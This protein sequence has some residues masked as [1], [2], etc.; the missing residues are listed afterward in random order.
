MTEASVRKVLPK[1]FEWVDCSDRNFREAFEDIYYHDSDV[2]FISGQGGCGKSVLYELAYHLDPRH[3]KALASTGR[4]AENLRNASGIPAS[5]IHSGLGLGCSDLY[6]QPYM[7]EGTTKISRRQ[8]ECLEG[9]LTILIDEV[10]MVSANLMD[11]IFWLRE[12]MR[13]EHGVKIRL[14]LFGDPL[15]LPPVVTDDA[16]EYW[17]A[18]YPREWQRAYGNGIGFFSSE[19]FCTTPKNTVVLKRV[20]RQG[21][22]QQKFKTALDRIRTGE[23]TRDDADVF[24][25]RIMSEQAFA[26]R[27]AKDECYLSLTGRNEEA[28]EINRK[29]ISALSGVRLYHAGFGISGDYIHSDGGAETEAQY[30]KEFRSAY[31]Q[32]F[33]YRNGKWS[34]DT[35][36]AVGMQVMVM[37]NLRKEGV[38]NGTLAWIEEISGSEGDVFDG[39]TCVRI[40]FKGRGGAIE[41]ANITPIRLGLSR[42]SMEF[43]GDVFA[44]EYA[45]MMALPIKPAYA[46]TFHKAQGLTLDHVYINSATRFAAPGAMYV[47][48]SRARTLEGIGLSAPLDVSRLSPPA[49]A[50]SFCRSLL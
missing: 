23:A 22:G 43:D 3:T 44:D 39:M 24:T 25:P 48:L 9:V 28:D 13:E 16:R 30:G 32:Y 5:T 7:K 21:D 45:Y 2:L 19:Y 49:D 37:A 34:A 40:R 33:R 6:R 1:G 18:R 8:L 31:P 11:M 29:R 47:A 12:R 20:M 14:I 26:S 50:L 4:A 41:H 38:S 35:E 46:L 36:L 42:R 15:Q 17:S 27:L 10:S